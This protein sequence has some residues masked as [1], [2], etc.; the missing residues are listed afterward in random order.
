MEG[1]LQTYVSHTSYFKK[2]KYKS[3]MTSQRLPDL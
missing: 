2:P 3:A 1:S